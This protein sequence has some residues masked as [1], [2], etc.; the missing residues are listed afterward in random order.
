MQNRA[1]NYRLTAVCGKGKTD[2]RKET[3]KRIDAART[4]F[5]IGESLVY[6]KE[7]FT[8][9][10]LIAVSLAVCVCAAACRVKTG[11]AELLPILFAAAVAVWTDAN[12]KARFGIWKKTGKV[13]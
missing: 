13:L 7:L 4:P 5:L 3:Q 8:A 12:G 10:A 1:Y 6:R 11:A 9:A 2:E